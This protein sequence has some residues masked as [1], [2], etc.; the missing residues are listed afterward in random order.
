MS[1]ESKVRFTRSLDLPETAILNFLSDEIHLR[2]GARE[3]PR[4]RNEVRIRAAKMLLNFPLPANGAT[5]SPDANPSASS[6]PGVAST[7]IPQRATA[8][9]VVDPRSK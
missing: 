7:K 3:G 2:I 5:A 8:G 9:G 6:N 1:T 4:N